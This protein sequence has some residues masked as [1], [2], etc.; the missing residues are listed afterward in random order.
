[1]HCEQELGRQAAQHTAGGHSTAKSLRALASDGL[2][3]VNDEP[4]G[5]DKGLT[6][7]LNTVICRA[8]MLTAYFQ[9]VI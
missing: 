7:N 2:G 9:S 3:A 6:L 4:C 8:D 1:M 5:S